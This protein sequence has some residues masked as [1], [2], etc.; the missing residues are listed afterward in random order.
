MEFRDTVASKWYAVQKKNLF[1]R[2]KSFRLRFQRGEHL[3]SGGRKQIFVNK[4]LCLLY[5]ETK[6]NLVSLVSVS[7][8][9]QLRFGLSSVGVSG[10]GPNSGTSSSSSSSSSSTVDVED[11]SSSGLLMAVAADSDYLPWHISYG[12]LVMA[13]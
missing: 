12:I 4:R 7:F 9:S 6:R 5:D 13:Y 1:C 3:L 10:V 11:A 2:K 8:V